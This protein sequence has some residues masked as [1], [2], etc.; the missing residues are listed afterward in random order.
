MATSRLRDQDR[1]DGAS[2]YVIWKERMSFLLDEYGLKPFIDAVVAIPM[3]TYQL[4]EYIKGMVQVKRLILDGVRDH[5]V[6]HIVAKGMTKEMWNTLSMLYQGTS[7]QRK[8]YLEEKLRLIQM[9]KGEGI[10]PFLTRIQEV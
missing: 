10:D 8:M 9:Q 2:N 6:S 5:V 4:K 7:K 3:D 1:L